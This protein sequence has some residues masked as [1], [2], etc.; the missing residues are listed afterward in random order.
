MKRS[1]TSKAFTLIEL[2]VVIS[3]I[4]LLIGILLPALGAARKTAITIQC[5]SRMRQLG[6]ATIAYSV[7]NN[8]KFPMNVITNS[9]NQQHYWYI[10]KVLGPYLPPEELTR[11]ASD[12]NASI[13]GS[14]MRCP[15][16]IDEAARS[17]VINGWS[18]SGYPLVD[19]G[20]AGGLYAPAGAGE[21]FTDTLRETTKTIL[22]SEIHSVW[23]PAGDEGLYWA[24]SY[25]GTFGSPYERFVKQ[26]FSG[27][28]FAGNPCES[29]IDWSRH[30]GD[31]EL[32]AKGRANFGFVDGHVSIYSDEEVVDHSTQKSTLDIV[33][34]ELDDNIQ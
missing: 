22:F 6:I 15:G 31:D 5:A 29:A 28:R 1:S 21:F 14:V 32:V 25:F 11:A 7:D 12:P 27:G 20:L 30:G 10:K 17:Y 13:G 8:G 4:A 16:D 9:D 3:I 2:L 33:W 18:S 19:A 26:G 24:G 23:G 34:S